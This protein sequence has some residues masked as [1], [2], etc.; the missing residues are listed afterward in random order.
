M[1]FSIITVLFATLSLTAAAAIPTSDVKLVAR[2][3]CPAGTYQC[4]GSQVQVCGYDATGT[5]NWEMAADCGSSMH[6]DG[7]SGTYVCIPEAD[8]FPAWRTPERTNEI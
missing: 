7:T 4:S 2:D 8:S 1:M 3:N 6:C 5:L